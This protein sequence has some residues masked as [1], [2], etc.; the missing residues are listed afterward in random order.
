MLRVRASL[1]IERNISPQVPWAGRKFSKKMAEGG[2]NL[3]KAHGHAGTLISPF[4][5]HQLAH[6]R[7]HTATGSGA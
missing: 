7:P 2:S 4:A 6:R 5:Q 1:E 3:E